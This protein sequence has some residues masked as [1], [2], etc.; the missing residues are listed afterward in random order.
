MSICPFCEKYNKPAI[1]SENT[2]FFSIY[3][4]FPVTKGHLLII[5]KRHFAVFFDVKNEE[6]ET[7]IPFIREAKDRLLSEDSSISG[8]N[9]G[10]NIGKTAGQS[11]EHCHLHLIPR[12]KGD[13][14]TPLGG[15]RGVIPGKRGYKN[16]YD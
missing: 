6:A 5:P 8:F 14:D 15:V 1:L 2:M 13:T 12:R 9:I 16:T 11:I 3:D 10:I 4:A 7:L